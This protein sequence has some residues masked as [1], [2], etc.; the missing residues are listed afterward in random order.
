MPRTPAR[1]RFLGGARQVT[2]SCALL[3]SA[4]ARVLVDCGLHQERP[5]QEKNWRPFPFDPSGLDAVFLTHAHLDHSGLL[6]KLVRDG[7]SGQILTTPASA[8]IVPIVLHDSARIQEEDAAFKKKR[9]QKEGRRGRFPEEPLY[10]THDVDAVLP[11]LDT[12]GYGEPVEFEDITATFHDAGHILG[13]AMIEVQT[14]RPDDTGTRTTIF[15]GDIGQSDRPLLRDP[16]FFR[17][18]D[19]AVMEGTYGDRSHEDR[20]LIDNLLAEVINRTVADGGNIL[21]PTF[22]IDRAQEIMFFLSRLAEEKRIPKLLTFLDSPMAV[23]VTAVYERHREAFDEETKALFRANRDPFRFPGLKYIRTGEESKAINSIKGSCIIMAGSGMC[24]GGRI[25][26]HLAR[27]ISRP[28][29]TVLFVGYQAQGT[30]GRIILDGAKEVRIFGKNHP[31]RARI[32][33]IQG[34]SAHADRPALLRWAGH[35]AKPLR[36]LFLNHGDPD[37]LD[38]LAAALGPRH[39]QGIIVPA[40]GE[41]FALH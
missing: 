5:H 24:T 12:V 31:V 6:P 35:F 41:T 27:N 37:V 2:G 13:S 15:S 26:H 7:F 23:E 30:L 40:P 3:E 8:E 11:L 22:A 18:A 38:S 10:T 32:R 1:L 36:R 14:G 28:E 21:I 34:F 33:Q 39:A 19:Y 16:S 9:H 25:K 20:D 29:S 17:E 4:K